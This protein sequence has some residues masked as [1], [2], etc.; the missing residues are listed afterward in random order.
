LGGPMIDSRRLPARA[1]LDTM[2]VSYALGDNPH[3]REAPIC[4]ALWSEMLERE[5]TIL[6]AAPSV[7]ELMR[8]EHPRP[9]PRHRFIEVVDFDRRSAEALG[10][11]LPHRIIDPI[12]KQLKAPRDSIKYDAMIV[13]CAITHL[14][15]V[16]ISL[17]GQGRGHAGH[18][19]ARPDLP[20]VT[21]P[22]L[23]G[24]RWVEPSPAARAARVGQRGQSW[25]S[26]PSSRV[27]SMTSEIVAPTYT[28]LA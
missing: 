25:S 2:V 14:A 5:K 11:R 12:A 6:I 16:I 3:R 27:F 19:G 1:L 9:I 28:A 15:E 4:Q 7:A 18:S 22:R 13:A 8:A 23:V 24:Y 17:D 10:R 26:S 21:D 20:N